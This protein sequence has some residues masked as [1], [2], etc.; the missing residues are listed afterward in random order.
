MKTDKLRPSLA[1]AA[2]LTLLFMMPPG[3]GLAGALE[4]DLAVGLFSSLKPDMDLPPGWEPLVFEKI[5]RHTRYELVMDDGVVVVKAVSR[6]A[7]SGLIRKIQID[8]MEYPL[9]QWRWKVSNILQKGDVT[10]K[11]GDDYPARIY[12]TFAYD[13][14][15]LSFTDNIKYKAAKVI[16]GEYPPTGA[17]N[18][19]WG[20]QTAVGTTVPSPYVH[21]SMMIVVESG[22]ENIHQWI[23]HTRNLLEDFRNAFHTDPPRITG[24]AIMTDT[25]NTGEA[26]TAYYGDIVFKKLPNN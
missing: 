11:Q 12:I 6:A 21:R 14:S 26:A 7:A 25:D 2:V 24:V 1:F 16:F 8:P 19:I 20:N 5:E 15:K 9:V 23:T 4:K 17:I 18:Y 13:P 10:Q 22:G 3:Q